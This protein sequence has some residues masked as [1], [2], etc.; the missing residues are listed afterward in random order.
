[1]KIS[2]VI[3]CRNERSHI[4]EFLDSLLRQEMRTDW[5]ME[6]LVADGLSDDGTREILARY[7][8]RTSTVRV[9]DNP[10]RIVSTGLNAAIVASTG[11]I[12]VRM[13]AHTVYA[14]NYIRECVH[15][16]QVSGAD[17]VGGPWVAEGRGIVG[18][19]IAAA[20]RSPFC[21]GGG[22]AHDADYEGEVDTVYLGCWARSTFDRAGLF[23][24]TL[25]RN[26]DDEFNFRLR[27]L[28]GRIWQSPRIK[29]SYTPRASIAALFRQYLQYGFWKVAVIRKHRALASWRHAV[30][31]MFVGWVLLSLAL[32]ASSLALGI[33]ALASAVWGALATGLAIYVVAAVAAAL[34]FSRSLDAGALLILPCVIAVYHIAYGLGFLSGILKF[35]GGGTDARGPARAFTTLTR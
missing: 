20:F 4:S 8:E 14:R 17:N 1:M 19:A 21:T 18:R 26:Q 16:L 35:A 6:I 13:D 31:V 3:P 2:V 7:C 34:P 33:G 28:G 27:R 15:A 9:I 32:I 24:S 5:Q 12:I 30:P 29:S 23:D 22:K 10:G 11:D 25:V